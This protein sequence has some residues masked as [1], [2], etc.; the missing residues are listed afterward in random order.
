M[1]CVVGGGWVPVRKTSNV[2]CGFRFPVLSGVVV[3]CV[4]VCV[5]SS[6][7]VLVVCALGSPVF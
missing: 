7:V 2:F 3:V 1:W 4:C 5:W 6:A